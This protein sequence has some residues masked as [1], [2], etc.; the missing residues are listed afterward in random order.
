M[1]NVELQVDLL[2]APLESVA[3]PPPPPGDFD[4]LPPPPPPGPPILPSSS[5]GENVSPP[6][7]PP[8]ASIPPLPPPIG[9]ASS[10]LP[11]PLPGE[12]LPAIFTRK[13]NQP[14]RPLFWKKVNMHPAVIAGK[15]VPLWQILDC[16]YISTP[17]LTCVW[18][19]SLA[20]NA[21]CV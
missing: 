2:S 11:P 4:S 18:L 1:V 14:L 9:E 21:F 15:L 16:Q 10:P 3:S 12:A 5:T 20:M 19:Y 6:P 13:P 8:G 17:M 7:P